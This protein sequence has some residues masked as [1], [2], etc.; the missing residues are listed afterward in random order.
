[1]N[2]AFN[3]P[4]V[5]LE[6]VDSISSVTCP[7]SDKLVATFTNS[8]L[9]HK[10]V[11]SWPK[12][13]FNLVNN[14]D[15]CG[16]KTNQRS[17]FQVTSF[18]V[19]EKSLT[20]EATGQ[21]L[22]LNDP[23]LSEGFTVSFGHHAS[24][25]AAPS[26]VT[27]QAPHK[28]H[29]I[30]GIDD[31]GGAIK[32]EAHSVG[33]AVT[34]AVTSVVSTAASEASSATSHVAS[35]VSSATSQ[36]A[37]HV[38]SV[39]TD[40][41]TAAADLSS[42]AVNGFSRGGTWTTGL[43]AGPQP[44]Q[45]NQSP[46]GQAEKLGSSDGMTI[47]CVKCGANGTIELSGEISA[48][49]DSI[50][51]GNLNFQ[52]LDFA[53]PLTFGFEA[54]DTTLEHTLGPYS[55][56][57]IPL[58]PFEVEPFFSVGPKFTFAVDF[59]V[60][61]GATG[62]L[63]AGVNM[64]WGNASAAMDL[65]KND[66]NTLHMAGWNPDVE[67][68]F[69][70]S[71]GEMAINAS[72]GIP[73]SFDIGLSLLQHNIGKNVSITDTPSVELDS[74]LHVPGN[75]RRGH[76]R[77]LVVR[78]NQCPNGVDETIGFQNVVGVNVLGLWKTQLASFSTPLWSTCITTSTLSPS[79][80][81]SSGSPSPSSVPATTTAPSPQKSNNTAIASGA[82]AAI[83]SAAIFTPTG[84]TASAGRL[85]N[86]S[87]STALGSGSRP[88][89]VSSLGPTRGPTGA[90]TALSGQ[91]AGY[92]PLATGASASMAISGVAQPTNQVLQVRRQFGGLEHVV[93]E[94]RMLDVAEK[95]I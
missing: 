13:E 67:K 26:P 63:K 66:P 31:I 69:E 32:S 47:W 65:V 88:S 78:D 50:T 39:V 86:S 68:V 12:S 33:G 22:A 92:L 45:L 89:G 74:T 16:D 27:T 61:V 87:N 17:A 7:S 77:D 55:L 53:I 58:T 35:D 80:S 38:S 40:A 70:F 18:Q 15:G 93:R 29:G 83:A 36:V 81:S 9:F 5:A 79:A 62:N 71:G 2:I 72:L 23:N 21:M 90:Y 64:H 24:A 25:Q 85:P 46:F 60:V 6:H 44:T 51:A 41:K 34:S 76:A 54:K 59:K 19:D 43:S 82:T 30:R 48:G 94:N 95:G 1:M 91:G 4:T 37:S 28:N 49:V 8:D 20:I 52:A 56:F 14:A 42:E 11:N 75:A 84:G 3:L 10:A 73:I 57:E